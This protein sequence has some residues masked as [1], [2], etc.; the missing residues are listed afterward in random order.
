MALFRVRPHLHI[1]RREPL[2]VDL[3]DRA[4]LIDDVDL[5]RDSMQHLTEHVGQSHFIAAKSR[6]GQRSQH[7]DR[8]LSQGA[9][10]ERRGKWR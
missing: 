9:W 5:G 2:L 6:H 8:F 3:R 4:Q 7:R 1:V 10:V